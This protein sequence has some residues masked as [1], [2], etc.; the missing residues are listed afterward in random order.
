MREQNT[1]IDNQTAVPYLDQARILVHDV[2][3]WPLAPVLD[4]LFSEDAKTLDPEKLLRGMIIHLRDAGAPINR[5]RYSFWTIH[6]QLAAYSYIWD[7]RTDSIETFAVPHGIRNTAAFIGSPAEDIILS[8]KPKRYHLEELDLEKEHSLLTELWE[9]GTTDYFGI[10]MLSASGE[11][12]TLFISTDVEGGFSEH[13]INKFKRLSDFLQPKV[14][15]LSMHKLSVELLNTY[16]GQRTGQRVL[17]GNIKRGDGETIDAAL[18]YSDLRDFTPLTESLPA[19]ELLDILNTYFEF[20]Y[21]AVNEFGGE[22]LRFVGDA[23]LIVFT[24]ETAGSVPEACRAALNAAEKA[25][26]SL[27]EFNEQRSQDGKSEIRFGVGLHEGRVIYGNVGAPSRLDFTVMGP[28]VNRTA[29]LE[30]LTKKIGSP[31]L[32]SKDFA[33]LSGVE[34]ISRGVHTMKGVAEPQEVFSLQSCQGCY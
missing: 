15:V 5:V 9:Q 33:R 29:R 28:A 27:A 3:G 14:E 23:M 17:S 24:E 6:P 25:F 31:L 21:D 12:H 32:M 2:D 18:W 19:D 20:V 13:D 7:K 16:V 8:K 4:W 22:V 11:T 34:T 26:T 10:P 1:I 30:G